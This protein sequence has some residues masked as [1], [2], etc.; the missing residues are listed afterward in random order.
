VSE[1]T[2][3]CSPQQPQV[4]QQQHQ[5]AEIQAQ[6]P[7]LQQAKLELLRQ[8]YTLTFMMKLNY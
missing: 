7:L 5:P 6:Q 8:P 2:S 3:P 1:V 4:Q